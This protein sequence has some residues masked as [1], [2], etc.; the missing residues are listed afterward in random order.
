MSQQ[1]CLAHTGIAIDHD[2][3]SL[4]G[5]YLVNSTSQHRDFSLTIHQLRRTEGHSLIVAR[6]DLVTN[7]IFNM[8]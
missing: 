6:E 4:P 2:A 8:K 3:P 1:G 7:R 5:T